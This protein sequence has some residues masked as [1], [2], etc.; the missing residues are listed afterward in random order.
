MP[1]MYAVNPAN[2]AVPRDRPAALGRRQLAKR[3]LVK[4]V[5]GANPICTARPGEVPSQALLQERQIA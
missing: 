5:V 2:H 4:N 1:A 3:R